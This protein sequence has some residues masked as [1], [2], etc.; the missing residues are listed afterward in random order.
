MFVMQVFLIQLLVSIKQF[1]KQLKIKVAEKQSKFPNAINYE[2]TY[3]AKN[4]REFDE[5]CTAPIHNYKGAFDYWEKCSSKPLIN[6]IC[7]SSIIINAQND[8]FLPKECY[9]YKEC[10]TNKNVKL[11]TP[12][13]G[14]HVGFSKMVDGLNYYEKVILTFFK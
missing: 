11:L 2:K 8:P 14:G 7:T 3:N 1:L 13:Y 9:P 5:H 4:F 10:E 12:K 6:N